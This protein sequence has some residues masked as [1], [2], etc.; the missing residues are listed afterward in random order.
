MAC[1]KWF[2][3][4][5]VSMEVLY[6]SQSVSSKVLHLADTFA[7]MLRVFEEAKLWIIANLINMLRSQHEYA[8]R[9]RHDAIR[10]VPKRLGPFLNQFIAPLNK[11]F[12]DSRSSKIE[13]FSGVDE[14]RKLEFVLMT[15]LV[16]QESGK[17]D[18]NNSPCPRRDVEA[19]CGDK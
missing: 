17:D 15:D 16:G 6:C 12:L 18:S 9:V 19:V 5:Q 1:T 10:L 3:T 13:W 14:R 8:T 4:K 7:Y 11:V 2:K